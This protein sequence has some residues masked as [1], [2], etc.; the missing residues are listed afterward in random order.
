MISLRLLFQLL[1]QRVR[2]AVPVLLLQ[3]YELHLAVL[4]MLL[5]HLHYE[6]LVQRLV[7][8]NDLKSFLQ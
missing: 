2:H 6:V 1:T 7:P 5:A 3:T 8:M 4:R